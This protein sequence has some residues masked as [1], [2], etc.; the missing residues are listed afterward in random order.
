MHDEQIRQW[1]NAFDEFLDKEHSDIKGLYFERILFTPDKGNK[2]NASL[3]PLSE[4]YASKE[5]IQKMNTV[6]DQ[7]L[8]THPV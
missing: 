6:F 3:L 1:Q 8:K 2:I 4:T 5:N 7:Y